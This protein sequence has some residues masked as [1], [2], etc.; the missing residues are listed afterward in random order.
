MFRLGGTG[1]PMKLEDWRLDRI[2]D[3][4]RGQEAV[5]AAD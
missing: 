2:V 4:V 5:A 3:K 1:A